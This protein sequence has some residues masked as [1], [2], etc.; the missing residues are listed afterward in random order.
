M[1]Q[2]EIP[3]L[4]LGPYVPFIVTCDGGNGEKKEFSFQL[5]F[6]FNALRLVERRTGIPLSNPFDFFKTLQAVENQ[7]ILFWA[8]T[9][10]YQPQYANESGL[11]FIG[12]I[13]TYRNCKAAVDAAFEAFLLS[14][15][16]DTAAKIREAVAN[17]K[18]APEAD[19][20]IQ[21]P[22]VKN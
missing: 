7:T 13:L 9:A 12:S 2:S 5:H 11:A 20:Q 22:A 4:W 21:V 6:N 15:P 17:P 10:A 3:S 8:A 16:D 19:P 1:A 18:E 14:L